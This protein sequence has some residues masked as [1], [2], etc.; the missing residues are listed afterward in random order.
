MIKI[1]CFT[2]ILQLPSGKACQGQAIELTRP[3]CKFWRKKSFMTLV[4]AGPR[5]PADVRQ[6]RR[7]SR[8]EAD[9]GDDFAGNDELR[10]MLYKTFYGRDLRFFIIS[11]VFARLS[12][13][14]LPR[15]KHSSLLQ[16]LVNYG[17][18]KFYNIGP[19]SQFCKTFNSRN[20]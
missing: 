13:K 11:C 19:W 7:R 8:I 17:E 4:P 2:K 20:L 6:G 15:T 5:E 9:V 1:F 12:W 3:I 14:S 18:K 16:R 10:P